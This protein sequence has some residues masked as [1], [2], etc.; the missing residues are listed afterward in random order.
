MH[1]DF[2]VAATWCPFMSLHTRPMPDTRLF[3][4]VTALIGSVI[5]SLSAQAQ[6]KPSVVI[7]M[8]GSGSMWGK[9]PGAREA[10]FK[11]VTSELQA[12]LQ[13][14]KA[15][16]NIGIIAFGQKSRVGCTASETLLDVGAYNENTFDSAIKRL[17]PKGR[18]PVVLGLRQASELLAQSQSPRYVFIIHDGPDNC[19][20][21]ICTAIS[22][23]KKQQP[24]LKA[25]AVSLA[26]KKAAKG[27]MSCLAKTTGGRIVEAANAKQAISGIRDIIAEI[28][29]NIAVTS[30]ISGANISGARSLQAGLN[31]TASL[32]KT[33]QRKRIIPKTPG[34]ML[35]ALLKKQGLVLRH[36]L[37]WKIIRLEGDAETVIKRTAASEPSIAL[38]PGRYAVELKTAGLVRRRNIEVKKGSRT[39]FPFHLDAAAVMFSA[40]LVEGSPIVEDAIF[41]ISKLQASKSESQPQHP[42]WLGLAPR[43][44]LVLDPGKYKMVISAGHTRQSRVFSVVAGQ[45][46]NLSVSLQAGYLNV[47][48]TKLS[49][50]RPNQAIVISIQTDDPSKPAGRRLIARSVQDNPNFLLPRGTYYISI[51]KGP[52]A[53]EELVAI[54]AGQLVKRTLIANHARLRITSQ[55][56][57]NNEIIDSQVR[58]RIW[59]QENKDGAP[60]V[61]SSA[62][63]EFELIPGKYHLEAKVGEQNAVITRDFEIIS[64]SPQNFVLD[65][66]AGTISLKSDRLRPDFFWEI[67]DEKERTVW[68]TAEMQPTLIL[69]SGRYRV[70]IDI[71]NQVLYRDI[72]IE[73]G[74]HID[75]EVRR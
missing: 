66:D 75:V 16:P 52:S 62:T 53:K 50:K 13:D 3:F 70:S 5:A 35:Q 67:K 28:G 68:R 12:A 54:A 58:Y 49:R 8:D 74:R 45:Q 73:S 29:Q 25:Y 27:T 65:I 34:L 22:A 20:Q 9:L 51:D 69:K 24:D 56:R 61:S 7:V 4:I 33:Q 57:G 72:I 40:A 55:L 26:L 63:S 60:I 19:Q 46:V 47:D 23:I 38:P 41:T 10:K 1:F 59:P 30:N 15:A 6:N 36:G 18:G 64:A 37:M 31:K 14:L 44:P 32:D 17:N 71:E 11:M 43:V 2:R 48:T 42:V 21:N 39:V